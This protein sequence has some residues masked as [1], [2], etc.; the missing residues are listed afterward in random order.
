MI[1]VYNYKQR[2]QKLLFPLMEALHRLRITPNMITIYSVLISLMIGIALWLNLGKYVLL[3]AP[4]G[5][6]FRMM[7]N[8]LDGMMATAYRLKSKK[9]EVFNEL[10]DVLSDLFIYLPLI[11]VTGHTSVIILFV[12]LSLLN[13]FAGILSK[14]VSGIRRYDGPMGKSDRAF[15]VGLY[16]LLLFFGLPLNSYANYIFAGASLLIIISTLVR[17]TKSIE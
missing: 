10:G 1:S 14:A 7:L 16:L 11:K 9:G 8:A 5:L 4:L 13:E 12:I 17:L 2:F 15:I 6:L 3:L